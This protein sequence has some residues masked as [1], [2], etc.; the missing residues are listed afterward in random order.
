M[1]SGVIHPSVTLH[2][3]ATPLSAVL[4]GPRPTAG[5]HRRRGEEVRGPR[6]RSV[7]TACASDHM[8]GMFL[9]EGHRESRAFSRYSPRPTYKGRR[10]CL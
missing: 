1:R 6:R 5:R 8:P 7:E 4:R 10:L 2:G 9:T 3:Q